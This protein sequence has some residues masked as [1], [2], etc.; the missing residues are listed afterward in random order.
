MKIIYLIFDKEAIICYFD[1][2]LIFSEDEVSHEMHLNIVFKSLQLV[3]LKLIEKTFE[4]KGKE[5]KNSLGT[6]F[7]ENVVQPNPAKVETIFK[8]HNPL[9]VSELKWMLVM[10]NF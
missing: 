10:M 9:N 5:T 8:M 2:I 6:L 1:S 3:R 4:L 7:S